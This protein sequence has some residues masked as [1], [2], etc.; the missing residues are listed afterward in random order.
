MSKMLRQDMMG[1]RARY[2]PALL[3]N[4]SQLFLQI[5]GEKHSSCPDQ[6]I[7]PFSDTTLCSG[8]VQWVV[9]PPETYKGLVPKDGRNSALTFTEYAGQSEIQRHVSRIW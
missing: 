9:S 6:S 7:L 5:S 8:F 4:S 2:S 1:Q 3:H